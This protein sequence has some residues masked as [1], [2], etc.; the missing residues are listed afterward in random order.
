VSLNLDSDGQGGGIVVVGG[1]ATIDAEGVDCRQDGPYWAKYGPA[2]DQF[3]L[4]DS[5]GDYGT[6]IRIR[7]DKVWTTPTA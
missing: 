6:R 2:A 4:T 1:E 7:I 5:M 3:G